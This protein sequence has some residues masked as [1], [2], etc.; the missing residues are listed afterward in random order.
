MSTQS[1][2]HIVMASIDYL[3]SVGGGGPPPGSKRPPAGGARHPP[4]RP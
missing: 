3:P 2:M 4:P 1:G